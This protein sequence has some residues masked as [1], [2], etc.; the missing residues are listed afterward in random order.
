MPKVRVTIQVSKENK[1][2][3]EKLA[4]ETG[5]SQN[6]IVDKLISVYSKI[7]DAEKEHY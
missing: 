2:K 7:M 6:Y 3:L 1:E 4:K 5:T